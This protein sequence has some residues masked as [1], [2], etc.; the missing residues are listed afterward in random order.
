M[1]LC[2]PRHFSQPMLL[3]RGKH[4]VLAIAFC[5]AFCVASLSPAIATPPPSKNEQSETKE[6]GLL[7]GV[8]NVIKGQKICLIP[9]LCVDSGDL[10]EQLLAKQIRE[11]AEKNA[12]VTVSSDN[13]FPRVGSLP[14]TPFAPA[15]L[16]LRGASPDDV[17]P[18][19]DY[20][21]PVQVFCLQKPAGSPN[22]HRYLVGQYGGKRKQVLAALNKAASTAEIGHTDLQNLSW[23]IQ[24]GV[25][26]EDMPQE[27]QALADKLIPDHRSSLKRGWLED[28]EAAW[29]TGSKILNLPSFESFLTNQLGDA[30]SVI[31]A[32]RQVR[33]R[34]VSR[35]ADWRNLSEIFIIENGQQGAGNVLNT[36][37]SQ[38]SESVH[39]RFVTDGNYN[40][41]GFLLLRVEDKNLEKTKAL[42]LLAIGAGALTAYELYDLIN[43]LMALPEGNSNIQPLAMSVAGGA[44]TSVAT[45]AACASVKPRGRLTTAISILCNAGTKKPVA[46][47]AG[48]YV[49]AKLPEL[50]GSVKQAF[51]GP[52]R[53]RTYRKGEVF[54]QA[55]RKGQSDPGSWFTKDMPRDPNHAD[56]MLNIRTW[57]N[58][59]IA[60]IAL[61]RYSSSSA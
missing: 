43:T 50:T 41:T 19:G 15:L 33:N 20:V 34:L 58:D 60:L 47:I 24:A 28:I 57:G 9:G 59:A 10:T 44:A 46:K 23:A 17:I 8:I 38:I 35:G 54:H 30:G 4:R 37:W 18:A 49:R 7:D 52:I 3:A 36:P 22:G 1:A 32:F 2:K 40:D 5:S 6:K 55:Q 16:D 27:M 45:Q 51:D 14:G 53:Q 39:A 29:N 31:V 42:P 25:A 21:V 48:K 13:L 26:Y 56:E 12:P 61:M 11:L